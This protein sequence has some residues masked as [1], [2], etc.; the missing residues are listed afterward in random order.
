[1]I[2]RPFTFDVIIAIL[3]FKHII[4]LFA[5]CL[6]PLLFVSL[7]LLFCPFCVIWL[8]FSILFWLL[9][10]WWSPSIY[11]NVYM[12][13]SFI[14]L[15]IVFSPSACCLT[16]SFLFFFFFDFLFSN[17]IFFWGEDLKFN[18]S[19]FKMILLSVLYLRNLCLSSICKDVFT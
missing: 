4:L 11:E 19:L 13:S 18:F 5:F 15:Y 12:S 14:H 7:F 9:N 3:P 2:F 1:M 16:F 10:F 17:H 8:I 6:F